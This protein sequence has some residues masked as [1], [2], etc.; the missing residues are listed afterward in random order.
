MT[1]GDGAV[2]TVEALRDAGV[3]RVVVPAFVFWGHDWADKLAAYGD[4]V[5]ARFQS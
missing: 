4:D 3:H 2:E 1:F 5:I